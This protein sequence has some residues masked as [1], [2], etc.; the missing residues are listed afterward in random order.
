MIGATVPDGQRLNS[1]VS[2][3][4][5]SK[6]P[7]DRKDL[8]AARRYASGHTSQPTADVRRVPRVTKGPDWMHPPADPRREC[9]SCG[10]EQ[11]MSEFTT[12][13]RR[14]G[15]QHWPNCRECRRAHRRRH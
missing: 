15:T 4:A 7:S 13:N 10:V 8:A 14:Y 12:F 9:K 2:D 6:I 5:R 3:S 11:H 1:S